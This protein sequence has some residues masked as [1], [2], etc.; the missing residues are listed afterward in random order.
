MATMYEIISFAGLMTT[1]EPEVISILQNSKE[2]KDAIHKSALRGITVDGDAKEIGEYVKIVHQYGSV[3]SYENEMNLKTESARILQELKDKVM[4]LPGT[5]LPGYS[6]TKYGGYVSSDVI[7]SIHTGE[8]TLKGINPFSSMREK[9]IDLLK[10]EVVKIGCNAILELDLDQTA[11]T[12][13]TSDGIIYADFLMTARGT[14]VM[15]E[16]G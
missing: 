15:V 4:I 13:P 16:K 5:G 3:E 1:D 10:A 14:A 6:I 7:G 2:Y 12:I 11:I 8:I 9:A